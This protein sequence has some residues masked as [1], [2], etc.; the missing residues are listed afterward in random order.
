MAY[1]DRGSILNS[2]TLGWIS[3]SLFLT[4]RLP[5]AVHPLPLHHLPLIMWLMW[6]LQPPHWLIMTGYGQALHSIICLSPRPLSM[7]MMLQ[8]LSSLIFSEEYRYLRRTRLSQKMQDVLSVAINFQE[9]GKFYQSDL[10]LYYY[11]SPLIFGLWY[12]G[13]PFVTSQAGDAII[14]LIGIK[15]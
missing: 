8:C 14:G 6:I 12:R 11:K 7:G 2:T 5:E 9:Q 13:I 15:D 4:V 10:G 1:H 3:I